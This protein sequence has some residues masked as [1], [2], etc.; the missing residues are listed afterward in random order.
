MKGFS[1]ADLCEVDENDY[2]SCAM[3]SEIVDMSSVCGFQINVLYKEH[4]KF[5]TNIR[6]YMRSFGAEFPAA[7]IGVALQVFGPFS[8]FFLSIN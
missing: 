7:C 3:G 6:D 8:C 4:I 1:Y 2:L 5:W